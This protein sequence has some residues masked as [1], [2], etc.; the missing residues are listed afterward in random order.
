VNYYKVMTLTQ[1]QVSRE[2]FVAENDYEEHAKRNTPP[3]LF[4]EPIH[5]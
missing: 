1:V 3:L 4:G 2:A 5:K